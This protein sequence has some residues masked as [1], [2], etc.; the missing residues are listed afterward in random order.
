MS[1]TLAEAL[2]KTLW[3]PFFCILNEQ[4]KINNISALTS[5]PLAIKFLSNLS[6][7]HR[8]KG[9]GVGKQSS[10]ISVSSPLGGFRSQSEFHVKGKGP[11]AFPYLC[12]SK[13]KSNFRMICAQ[14]WR[15]FMRMS[16]TKLE[17]NKGVFDCDVSKWNFRV[18]PRKRDQSV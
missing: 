4:I 14:V 5:C 12:E 1:R 17:L 11:R 2:E 3:S 15:I 6:L 13:P 18:Q 8:L 7:G 10:G 16:F 9:W